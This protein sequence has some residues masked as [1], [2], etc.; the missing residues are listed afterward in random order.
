MTHFKAAHE[1]YDFPEKFKDLYKNVQFPEP[2]N[3]YDFGPNTT[4][5]TF[6]G[7]KIEELVRRWE[8][9]AK[10][11]NQINY[12]ELP[13]EIIGLDSIQIRK[14]AYQK[15]I[16]DYLR[17]T[18]GIN[19]NLGKILQYLDQNNL[20]ENTVVIYTSDQGYFL[21]EHGFFDKR[22]FLEESLRMPFVIRYPKEI[23]GGIRIDDIILNIDIPALIADYGGLKKIPSFQG[24]SFRD[25]LL[26]KTSPNWRTSMYYRYYAH[27]MSR[28]AHFGIRNKR[29]K[30]IFYYGLP[31]SLKGSYTQTA[32]VPSWEFYDLLVDPKENYNE[33]QNSEYIET[34]Q[35]MK[36]EL[37]KIRIE[38]GDLDLDFPE[39][40]LIINKFWG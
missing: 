5:R 23:K 29:Y 12:P 36:K 35:Q 1:P 24:V 33:Y 31:L 26:Q 20:T 16:K 9:A 38:M 39:M 6:I 8:T 2:E 14:K 18:A 15:L 40:N 32:T 30:L 22:M 11:G 3:L 10:E 34:I 4:Q 25:N 21:G 37:I 19:D 28:P 7:Q 13:F 27:S 17:C